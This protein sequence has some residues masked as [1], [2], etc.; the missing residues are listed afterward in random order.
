MNTPTFSIKQIRNYNIGLFLDTCCTK[1]L[2][3]S[4]GGAGQ[5][6][7]SRMGVFTLQSGLVNGRAYY[8]NNK[9][10][11]IYWMAIHGGFWAVIL[12]S[13]FRS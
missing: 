3:T 7:S 12:A 4:T 1:L 11:Y 13:A 9:G 10:N 8:K 6:Q 2:M 5:K